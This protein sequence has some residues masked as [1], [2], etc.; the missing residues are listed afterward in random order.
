MIFVPDNLLVILWSREIRT[1]LT[2]YSSCVLSQFARITNRK[3]PVA[4]K[5][6]N[7]QND[8]P[9][10]ITW[11]Q[12]SCTTG[13]LMNNSKFAKCSPKTSARSTVTRT[14]DLT[15]AAIIIQ[16]SKFAIC[17]SETSVRST[18]KRRIQRTTGDLTTTAIICDCYRT[19]DGQ[20]P[21]LWLVMV[22]KK[23][24]SCMDD[25]CTGGAVGTGNKLHHQWY[26]FQS[27]FAKGNMVLKNQR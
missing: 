18:V 10:V 21:T 7:S 24:S 1:L 27:G 15:T 13:D 16:N 4:E 26:Q 8:P 6:E 14:G 19:S 22:M 2:N 23:L 25:W 20:T 17:S 9:P 5:F 3:I 12:E 11:E